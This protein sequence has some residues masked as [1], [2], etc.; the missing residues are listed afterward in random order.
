MVVRS[1]DEVDLTKF[2]RRVAAVFIET[3][4]LPRAEREKAAEVRIRHLTAGVTA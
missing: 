1:K 4:S 3:A 2:G